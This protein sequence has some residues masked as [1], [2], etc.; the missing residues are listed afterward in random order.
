MSARESLFSFLY[1][2][3]PTAWSWRLFCWRNGWKK[4]NG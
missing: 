2:H 3:L 4:V 1:R